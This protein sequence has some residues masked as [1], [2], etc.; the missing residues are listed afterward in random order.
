MHCL[1][2]TLLLQGKKSIFVYK[3]VH[4]LELTV[5]HACFLKFSQ[6]SFKKMVDA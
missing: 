5:I 4:D 6:K 3:I 2:I 1:T